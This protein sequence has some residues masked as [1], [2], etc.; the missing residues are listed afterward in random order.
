MP[1]NWRC[2]NLALVRGISS[3]I[4]EEVLA[5]RVC[6]TVRA[7]LS[8]SLLPTFMNTAIYYLRIISKDNASRTLKQIATGACHMAM[9]LRADR[10]R[11]YAHLPC[12]RYTSPSSRIS[13][14]LSILFRIGQGK[15]Q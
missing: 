10:A 7:T 13:L 3:L 1:L 12:S 8:R 4:I 5:Q 6:P 15:E 11:T 2:M 14:S 9:Y